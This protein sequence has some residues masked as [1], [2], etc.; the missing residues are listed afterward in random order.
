VTDLTTLVDVTV[1]HILAEN[2]GI[3]FQGPSPKAPFDIDEAVAVA[4]LS[5]PGLPE[6]RSNADVV[7]PV[8]S[9]I[10]IGQ[11]PRGKWTIDFGLMEADEAGLYDQPFT[12]VK[13]NILP[14]LDTTLP[15]AMV[16]GRPD[17]RRSVISPGRHRIQAQTDDPLL[18]AYR[19]A[20]RF[21]HARMNYGRRREHNC[22]RLVPLPLAHARRAGYCNA[23][24]LNPACREKELQKRTLTNLYNA[25]PDWLDAAHSGWTRPSSPPTAGRM[26][27]RMRRC[28]RGCWR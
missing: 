24:W 27:W 21:T 17:M 18:G 22:V 3:S 11:K 10:D 5:A 7:R 9:A 28:W 1:A 14:V 25:R 15:W 4:M 20:D 8:I 13:T 26:I 23:A 6:G 2:A 16:A 19:Q 12:Y